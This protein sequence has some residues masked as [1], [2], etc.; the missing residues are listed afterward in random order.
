MLCEG[1][2]FGIHPRFGSPEKNIN[3]NFSKTNTKCCLSLP[4]NADKSY[5][6]VSAK[7]VFKFKADNKNINFST[8]FFLGSISNGFNAAESITILLISPTYQTFANI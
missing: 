1:S 4:Y 6:F 5:L 3:I 7:E 8:Q 2:T